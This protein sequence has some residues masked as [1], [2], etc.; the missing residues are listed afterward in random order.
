MVGQTGLIYLRDRVAELGKLYN[1]NIQDKRSLINEIKYFHKE[2]NEQISNK[3]SDRVEGEIDQGFIEIDETTHLNK[4][5]F[6]K[7]FLTAFLHNV[8][9]NWRGKPFSPMLSFSYG[10]K[11]KEKTRKSLP[12]VHYMEIRIIPD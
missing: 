1:E 12:P 8:G 11:R 4:L 5:H 10:E 6:K 9:D 3:D 2:A 7:I